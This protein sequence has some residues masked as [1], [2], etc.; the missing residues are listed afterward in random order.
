[1]TH[2]RHCG[3]ILLAIAFVLPSGVF[4]QVTTGTPPFSSTSGGSFD[5]VNLANLNV[6]FEIPI[7]SRPGRGLPFHYSLTYDSSVWYPVY[8]DYWSWTSVTNWG[9]QGESNALTGYITYSQGT[10]KCIE[11][12]GSFYY[13]SSYTNWR[14]YDTSGT[15][16]PFAV[17]YSDCLDDYR[18]HSGLATDGSALRLD[19]EHITTRS[20]IAISP[21]V[22]VTS[23]TGSIAD[24]NGNTL[25]AFPT[26]FTDT[27][28]SGESH[29][30]TIIGSPTPTSYTYPGPSG[31]L[32][33]TLTYGTFNIK[34]NLG[35]AG[36][37]DATKLSVSLITSVDL[38]GVGTY[39]ITYEDTPGSSGYKTG[40]IS[41][42]MLPTGGKI[43]Y[44]YGAVNCYDGS[45][46]SL[47]RTVY[48]DSS[49]VE[50]TWNYART[51]SPAATTVTAPSYNGVRAE[52]YIEFQGAYEARR[53]VYSG[54]Y[55]SRNP[56]TGLLLTIETC[57]S[58][59][60]TVPGFPCTTTEVNPPFGR[61]DRRTTYPDGKSSEVDTFL[62]TY[63]LPTK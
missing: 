5:T 7:F 58:T 2:L 16:H 34:T 37:Q 17:A 62:D 59:T 26:Y 56:N 57:Y 6:H 55:D 12:D 24:P 60:S 52:T 53:R 32:T 51:T 61:I 14:Y 10:K 39:S 50:G 42:I 35:C 20:G 28:D 48:K 8:S 31:S 3:I 54:G 1:M 46:L 25:S 22:N 30:L 11:E 41:Q 47:T 19:G 29:V 49:T 63:E 33:A 18:S 27:L 21:P 38:P 13:A 4:A 45:L 43:T 40:R 44:S 23:G 15:L 36:V 9:W